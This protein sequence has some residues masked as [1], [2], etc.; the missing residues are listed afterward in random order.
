M[1]RRK[2]I[3]RGIATLSVAGILAVG[4]LTAPGL[5]SASDSTHDRDSYHEQEDGRH[6]ERGD[7]DDDDRRGDHRQWKKHRPHHYAASALTTTELVVYGKRTVCA[8]VW[9]DAGTPRGYVTFKVPSR[10]RATL[11]LSDGKACLSWPGHPR[12]R[13]AYVVFAYYHGEPPYRASWDKLVLTA[14][15]SHD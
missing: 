4:Q 2:A 1:I 3:S 10:A 15:K 7:R 13:R 8:K 6:Q 9:S 14:P 11:A 12:S 5:V